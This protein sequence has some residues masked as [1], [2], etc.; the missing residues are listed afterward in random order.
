MLIDITEEDYKALMYILIEQ[1]RGISLAARIEAGLRVDPLKDYQKSI[2]A[3]N[4]E[5]VR[6]A[7]DSLRSQGLAVTVAAV[8]RVSGLSRVTVGKYKNMM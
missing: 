7:V 6:V 1:K 5:A 8:A 4:I 2:Q 3:Q